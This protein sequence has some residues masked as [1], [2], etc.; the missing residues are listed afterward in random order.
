[1]A[2]QM[3]VNPNG[4]FEMWERKPEGYYTV[5]EWN[6]MQEAA[7]QAQIEEE[8][9]AQWNFHDQRK[10]KYQEVMEKYQNAVDTFFINY[11]GLSWKLVEVLKQDVVEFRADNKISN[12]LNAFAN[13][14][15]MSVE[16]AALTIDRIFDEGNYHMSRCFGTKIKYENFLDNLDPDTTP[17][18]VA[19]IEIS[20]EKF[21]GP[22]TQ[23]FDRPCCGGNN[24]INNPNNG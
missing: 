24:T 9:L 16:K 2:A 12:N 19:D 20:F 18:V 13:A 7:R 15:E 17:E 4:N 22:Y 5:D 8:R 11:S 23:F 14:G 10:L 3:F 6:T 1:M 21:E